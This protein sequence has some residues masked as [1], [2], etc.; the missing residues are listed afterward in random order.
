KRGELPPPF[1]NR[2][3]IGSAGLND[4]KRLVDDVY[5]LV[6]GV[7]PYK[8]DAQIY[9]VSL[10]RDA[11][12][13]IS[14]STLAIKADAARLLFSIKCNK[15]RWAIVDTGVAADHPAFKKPSGDSRVEATYDF[16]GL[17]TLLDPDTEELPARIE[18]RLRDRRQRARLREC[19]RTLN[20]S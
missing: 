3:T 16:T 4:W 11:T 10:N 8:G 18:M 12:P 6:Q 1:N 20:A 17:D 14:R 13:T 9:S 15:L 7:S 19:L 5:D 2:R